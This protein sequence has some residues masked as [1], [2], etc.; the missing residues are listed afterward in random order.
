MA[1][2]QQRDPEMGPLGPGHAPENDPMKGVRGVMAGTLVLEAIVFLISLSVVW[3]VDSG[4]G[5]M[6]LRMGYVTVLGLAM[7]AAA[8][9]QKSPKAKQINWGLQVF[10]VIAAFTNL[11][12]GVMGLIFVAVWWYIY[13]LKKI[14]EERMRRGLLPSQHV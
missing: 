10:A 13:H 9:V 4:L 2:A 8:F 6:W 7:L 12:I 1:D 14:M 5:P 11:A 3:R